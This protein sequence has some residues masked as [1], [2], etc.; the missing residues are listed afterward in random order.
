MSADRD[1]ELFTPTLTENDDALE[2]DQPW[3]PWSLVVLTFFFG[4]LCGGGALALNYQRLGVKGRL[5]TTS[6]I[7][8]IGYLAICAAYAWFVP[9]AVDGPTGDRRELIRLV[10][11]IGG[12]L[13]AMGI[14]EHQRP[15]FRLF[16]SRHLSGGSLLWPIVAGVVIFWPMERMLRASFLSLY[17][18]L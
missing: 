12:C 5:F 1:D 14:A 18:M 6:V 7:V 10:L 17:R 8:V 13:I 9:L 4:L 2:F 3:N 16:Q 11:K 15:R